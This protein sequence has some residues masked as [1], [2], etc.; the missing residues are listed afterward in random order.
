[1]NYKAELIKFIQTAA[2]WSLSGDIS[3]QSMFILYG[4]R[5]NGKTTFLNTIIYLLG[6]YLV[7]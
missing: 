2:G 4:T 7:R 3:E 5:A 1:M 6:D